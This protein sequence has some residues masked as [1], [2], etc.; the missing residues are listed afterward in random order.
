MV[1]LESEQLGHGVYIT[2]YV[3]D[4]SQFIDPKI[5]EMEN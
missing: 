4:L 5:I 1:L 3:H 2:S